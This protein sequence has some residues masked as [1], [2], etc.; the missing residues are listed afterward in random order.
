MEEVKIQHY[1]V[2]DG[3]FARVREYL[4]EEGLGVEELKGT[5][6]FLTP[7]QHR[8]VHKL[9]SERFNKEV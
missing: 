9:E 4:L 8:M 5:T 2:R 1:L 7:Q 3:D 6:I